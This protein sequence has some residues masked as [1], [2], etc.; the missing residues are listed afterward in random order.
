MSNYI[1]HS[2]K[3]LVFD[4]DEKALFVN[5][6]GS[7]MTRQGVWKLIKHYA[8]CAGIQKEITPCMLRHSFATH[9]LENGADLSL[10]CDVLGH[11]D[12]SSTNVYVNLLKNKTNDT[13][14]KFH[15]HA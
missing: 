12:I 13:L 3:Y 7:R 6:N 11:S 4:E 1:S 14:L 5:V 9:L 8:E 15:P 10:L 2:R